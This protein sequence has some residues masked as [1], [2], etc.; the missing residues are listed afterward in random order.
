MRVKFKAFLQDNSRKD[1][2]EEM[3]P[4]QHDVMM[5]IKLQ[6]YD[7]IIIRHQYLSALDFNALMC[8]RIAMKQDDFVHN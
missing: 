7:N 6:N 4:K 8:F 5:M 3:A 2:E 1:D